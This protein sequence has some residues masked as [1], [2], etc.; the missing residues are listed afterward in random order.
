M[1]DDHDHRLP[2]EA[3]GVVAGLFERLLEA[4][5]DQ[6]VREAIG[7]LEELQDAMSQLDAY[8]A[9]QREWQQVG[10]QAARR[11]SKTRQISGLTP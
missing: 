11:T 6:P 9:F 8:N 4:N 2:L 1:L 10:G 5:A 7:D 3:F